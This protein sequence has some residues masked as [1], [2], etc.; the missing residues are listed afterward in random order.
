MADKKEASL[1][2]KWMQAVR[3]VP[4]RPAQKVW[5]EAFEF[6]PYPNDDAELNAYLADPDPRLTKSEK[7]LALMLATWASPN[8]QDVKPGI[9]TLEATTT[10]DRKTVIKTRQRLVCAG[11]LEEV[12]VSHDR[13]LKGEK[14]Q[15]SEYRLAIPERWNSSNAQEPST[16][17]TIPSTVGTIPVDRWN[18]SNKPVQDQPINQARRNLR[19]AKTH[20]KKKAS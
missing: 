18:G 6:D 8:G 11:W 14:R 19:L 10:L 2:Q 13:T 9:R 1:Q 15:A 20:Q 16:V 5:A 7:F 12:S 17:G 3:D 4:K